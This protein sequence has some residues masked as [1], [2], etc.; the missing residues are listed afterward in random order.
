LAYYKQKSPEPEVDANSLSFL[1][2]YYL[3]LK[4]VTSRVVHIVTRRHR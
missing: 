3:D 4:I 2:H 1:F